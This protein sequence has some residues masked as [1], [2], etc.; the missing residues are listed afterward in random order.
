[1]AE[2]IQL[3]RDIALIEATGA[4][5]HIDQLSTRA[6]LNILEAAKEQGINV[7][8]GASIHHLTLNEIDIEGYP[9]FF[10][11]KP[12]LRTEDDRVALADAVARGLIDIIHQGRWH[13]KRY[14][15][16]RCN[17]CTAIIWICQRYGRPSR[18]IRHNFWG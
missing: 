16:R 18:I 2:R 4:R 10:K 1:M 6:G 13:L 7:T 5:V 8:A 15:Q 14:C 17:W 12:P 3:E 9:T 11:L